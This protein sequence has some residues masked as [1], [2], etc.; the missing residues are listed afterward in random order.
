MVHMQF[1]LVRSNDSDGEISG[2]ALMA[3]VPPTSHIDEKPS[4]AYPPQM[5]ALGMKDL[6]KLLDLCHR[7]ELDGEVTPIMAWTRIMHDH[8]LPELEAEDFVAIRA[9]LLSKVRCY[10]LVLFLF[11]S[12]IVGL[13]VFPL[14]F[15]FSSELTIDVSL[16]DSALCWRSLRFATPSRWPSRTGLSKRLPT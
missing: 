13:F 12:I 5:P 1:L 9:D 14:F 16:P 8:R 10:G 11:F 6:A 3:T 2:H 15:Y 4:E 7:L